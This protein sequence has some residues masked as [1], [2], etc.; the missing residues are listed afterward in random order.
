[1]TLSRRAFLAALATTILAPS[2]GEAQSATR[3]AR[4]GWVGSGPRPTTSAFLD[5]FRQGLRDGG[6]IEG[7]TFVLET[8]WGAS[9][10][11]RELTL[12]LVTWKPDVIVAQGPMVFGVRAAAG[13]I[14]VV[15]GFS[16]DPVEAG[17]VASLAKPGGTL[18][19]MTFLGFELVGKRL[20]LLKDA[21]PTV[22]RVAIL[23]NSSHAG[24]QT[25]LRESRAAAQRL[26][27][28]V[29]YLPVTR[30]A[31][32]EAAFEAIV[33]ERAEAIVAFPDVLIVAQAGV[34][35]EFALRRRIP[36]I[37]G[38]AEFADAGNV[39]TYGPNL[40]ES[41]RQI[42]SCVDRDLKGAKPADLPVGLPTT[43][44]TVINVRAAKAIGLTIPPALLLRADRIIE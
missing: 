13:T 38:W 15:F 25:E 10:D 23:A 9:S 2:T 16:G 11:A 40:R 29:Q 34:V 41:W 3:I 8:R 4:I 1:M 22:S 6:W 32:F 33:R 7:R 24:E 26:G 36:A 14:P 31:D 37:S 17:V 44:E 20:E 43:F 42:A 21:M 28:T 39:M 12:G 30:P 27:M 5:A 19:G 18:T 35:A